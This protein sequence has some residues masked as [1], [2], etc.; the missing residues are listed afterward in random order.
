MEYQRHV[1][2][3]K[4]ATLPREF[5][6]SED[7]FEEERARIFSS[8]WVCAGRVSEL[9]EA[10]D[11]RLITIGEESLILL[12]GEDGRL[13]ALFNVC[14]HR[15]TQLCEK[16]EGHFAAGI[17]C[18]Y[19]AWTYGFDGVLRNAPN[20][21]G[22]SWFDARDFP[23]LGAN[24]AVWEGFVFVNLAPRFTP[25]EESL[26]PLLNRFAP[27]RLPEL[28]AARTIEYDVRA[29]WK[30][31][32]Q[33]FS[34]CDHCP[35]V[36]PALARL[37]PYRS[38]ANDL[39]EGPILG[40]YMLVQDAQGSLTRSGRLCAQPIGDLSEEE[41]GRVFYYSIFPSLFLTLLPD[42]VLATRITPLEP[43]RTRITC[44][45]LFAPEALATASV[46]PS[47]GI[48]FWDR[49]NREDWHICELA[50]RGVSSRAYEPGLYSVP[51]SLLAAFDR[52]YRRSLGRAS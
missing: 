50:Q 32:F 28:A 38:G 33:N 34:E 35:P 27:W 46:D 45:W 42:F 13:R 31:I 30:L 18:P 49:T 23:L 19:H 21:A 1:L 7:I 5:Y 39:R 22:A 41:R 26:A 11:Y 4:A 17:R 47:D 10:G 6:V 51:E 8:R 48:D 37:S 36:H 9:T 44:E 52:E 14:R 25:L 29:N 24:A 12:R 3:A 16:P 40:G 15:G 43:G 20:M 2:P